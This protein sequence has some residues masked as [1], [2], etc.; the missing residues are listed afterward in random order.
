MG[1]REELK[2]AALDDDIEIE[3]VCRQC[4]KHRY[5]WVRE[6]KG[7]ARMRDRYM[8]EVQA[9]LVCMDRRCTGVQRVQIM[10]DHLNQGFVGG[11]P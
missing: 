4:K 9:A 5:Y 10:H 2:L 7:M 3:V 1:W 8:D 11:M 6:L